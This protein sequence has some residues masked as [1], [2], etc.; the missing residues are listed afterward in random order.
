MSPSLDRT[1]LA[2]GEWHDCERECERLRAALDRANEEIAT[3]RGKVAHLD[4]AL[5]LERSGQKV[6]HHKRGE[7]TP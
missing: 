1:Q 4:A 3:L 6:L 7:P 2:L 5:A